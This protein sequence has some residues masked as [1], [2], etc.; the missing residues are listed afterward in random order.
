MAKLVLMRHGES[1]WNKR[2]RFCGWVDIALSPRG[3]R[4]SFELGKKLADI[5]FDRVFTSS[6]IR[7]QM[8][9]LIV[10]SLSKEGKIPRIIHQDDKRLQEWDKVYDKSAEN[11]CLPV[12]PA[13]QLN[14]RMYGELQGLDKQI[15]TEQF[16]KEQVQLWRRS[17]DHSPPKG[18]SL[19]KTA[20]RVFPY[21]TEQI[22]PFLIDG[23]NVLLSAHGNSLRAIIMNLDNLS[24]EQI[25]KYEIPTGGFIIYEFYKNGNHN[26]IT[27]SF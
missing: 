12:I 27:S 2:N 3:I 16:G 18:E 15:A 1:E 9:A 14:E 23:K 24:S 17:F 26:I 13:W 21:F 4:E 7:T 8:A 5:P 10:L 19:S 11:E 20:S 22:L 6:F 25:L